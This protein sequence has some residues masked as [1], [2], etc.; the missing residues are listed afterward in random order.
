MRFGEPIGRFVQWA[1]PHNRSE[2]REY[3]TGAAPAYPA[4]QQYPA[5]QRTNTHEPTTGM[6]QDG[7]FRALS[8]RQEVGMHRN[9]VRPGAPTPITHRERASRTQQLRTARRA[10]AKPRPA[11]N[12]SLNSLRPAARLRSCTVC[13][14]VSVSTSLSGPLGGLPL[15]AS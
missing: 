13:L 1:S 7:L 8:R 4:H 14:A 2:G 12:N 6:P 10:R 9:D 3:L 11:A 15:P 5:H